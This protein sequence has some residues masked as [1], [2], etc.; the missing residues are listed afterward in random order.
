MVAL[1]NVGC[2]LKLD[3]KITDNGKL[4]SIGL[5][6]GTLQGVICATGH[7]HC[8][9]VIKVQ[10]NLSSFLGPVVRRPISA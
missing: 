5:V 8:S 7:I 1:P 6:A 4:L 10:P 3:N 2:F 9:S